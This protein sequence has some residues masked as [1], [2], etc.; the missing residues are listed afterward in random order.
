MMTQEQ[1]L[2]RPK[3][4]LLELANHLG[5]VSQACKVMGYSRDSF[6]RFK[7]LYD[8][9]GALALQELTRKKPNL[10][11]RIAPEVEAAVVELSLEQPAWGQVRVS[12]EL[13]RR[14]L[15]I[16]PAGVRCVWIRHELQN[17]RLRLKALEAK[18]AQ[19]G[20]VLTEAQLQALEKKRDDEQAHG[21][22]ESE[23]PGYCGAQ[24]TFYVG[25]LKGVGRI[26]QQTFIDTYSKV[27]QAKLYDT[28]TPLTAAD[29]LNDRVVPLFEA[30]GISLLRVLTDRGTEYCGHAERHEYQLYLALE[31][32]DHTRT[33]A[34]SPQTNGICERFHK[35]VLDEF[36][37]IAFRKKIY[38]SIEDLQSDLDAW[39]KY[40]NEERTHQG[41]WCYGKTPMQTFIDT[42]PIAK[43]KRL[44]A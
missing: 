13:K 31:D 41:R 44:A 28:K 34:H 43:E 18:V 37:R 21:E 39:L 20:A 42:L 10:R 1:K 38:R 3:L 23:H 2:V 27:V 32:I 29:L 14:A 40:Y 15:S 17:I 4:G 6:Y 16:S 36:Y 19:E 35:T 24:D 30:H 33:K 26:Y 9:G 25:H 5:N 12:N 7:E 11:N 22:F 8:R